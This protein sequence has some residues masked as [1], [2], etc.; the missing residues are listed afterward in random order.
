MFLEEARLAAAR[1]GSGFHR[2]HEHPEAQVTVHLP[3]CGGSIGSFEPCIR[4]VP[5]RAPHKGS[6]PTGLIGGTSVVFHF[7]PRMLE[8]AADEIYETS[9][10]ELHGGEVR[11][12]LIVHLAEVAREEMAFGLSGF[13]LLDHVAHVLAGRLVR[14]FGSLAGGTRLARTSL[15]ARQLNTLRE[16]IESRLDTGTNVTQLAMAVGLGPQRLTAVLKAST[17]LTPHAYVTHLRMVRAARLLKEGRRTLSEIALALG[18][19][20]QSHFGAV[21]LRYFGVTPRHYRKQVARFSVDA[22]GLARETASQGVRRLGEILN[23]Q[24]T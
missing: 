18:F 8:S 15:S 24:K 2:E 3:A 21:F 11:D 1:R 22:S 10:F 6:G 20:G 16:F 17:G 19:A 12:P 5:P 13:G 23:L 4:I 14:T 7:P 9:H